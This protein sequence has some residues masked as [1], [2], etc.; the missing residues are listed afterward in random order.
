MLFTVW[1]MRGEEGLAANDTNADISTNP[2]NLF[3]W[4][5]FIISQFNSVAQKYCLL[6]CNYYGSTNN[7]FTRFIYLDLKWLFPFV[8]RLLSFSI[9]VSFIDGI[10]SICC[11]HLFLT[12][13]SPNNV[14]FPRECFSINCISNV[15]SVLKVVLR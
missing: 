4:I 12:I 3:D 5:S 2:S 1:Q 14:G 15:T 13:C 7:F 9:F 10:L 11:K 8:M 6:N